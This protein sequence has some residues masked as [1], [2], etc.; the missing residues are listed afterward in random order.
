MTDL[1]TLQLWLTEA[2]AARHSVMTTGAVTEIWRDGRRLTYSRESS[3]D[4]DSYI[5]WLQAEILKLTDAAN[6]TTVSRRRSISVIF[7]G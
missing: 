6:G 7:G 5:S 4:L 2:Q 1:A 3:R